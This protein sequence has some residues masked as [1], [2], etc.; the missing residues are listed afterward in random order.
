MFVIAHKP[1][2]LITDNP[3]YKIMQV[4][5]WNK[6]HFAE[7]TDDTGDNIS[8]KNKNYC[9]LTGQYWIWKNYTDADIVGICHYRR[10]FFDIP[11]FLK[12]VFT[13]HNQ[14]PIDSSYID[15]ALSK[16]DMIV[17]Y[18]FRGRF[19]AG[20]IYKYFSAH[21][22]QKDMDATRE[23]IND[24]YPD[25]IKAFDKVI[26][27]YKIH[28]CNMLVCRKDIFDAYSK[29]L[30]DVL[31][32]LEKRVDIS[33]YDEYQQR[34]FGFI[35]ERLLRV[36]IVKNNISI[37]ECCV[38]YVNDDRKLFKRIADELKEASKRRK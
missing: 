10:Y 16:H 8:E 32:E 4:G 35:S 38:H 14:K 25:Y 17:R 36:W 1:T 23:V 6:S 2:G 24:I 34:I 19:V 3:I 22:Y 11:N 15:K 37:R 30:F 7:F 31:F 21:H 5:A 29:W 26:F 18:S 27:G 28:P 20:S 13:G 12:I 9:E 33:D